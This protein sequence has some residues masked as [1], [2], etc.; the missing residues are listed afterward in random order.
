MTEENFTSFE[1]KKTTTQSFKPFKGIV[2]AYKAS[3]RVVI[4]WIVK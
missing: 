2:R 4:E 1:P 3:D